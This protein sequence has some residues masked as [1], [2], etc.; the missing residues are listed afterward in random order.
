MELKELLYDY[1]QKAKDAALKLATASTKDKNNA[2]LLMAKKLRENADEIKT[3]NEKDLVAGKEKGLSDAMLDR[4]K[5][6]EDRINSMAEGVEKIASLVDPVGE[7][8]K[9]WTTEE[10]IKIRKTRVPI[11]VVG[12][13]YESRPNV[14]ADAAA[15]SLKSGN[16]IILRG[17]KEA[18]NSN[19]V[20]AKYL[21]E[22]I[23]EVGLPEDCINLIQTIDREAVKILTQMVG[24]IDMIIP[25]GGSGLIKAVTEHAKVPV[26]FHDKGLCH[27]YVDEFANFDMATK[28]C[29]NAKVQRP[30][31]CNAMETLLINKNIASTY[32]PVITDEFRNAGVELRGCKRSLEIVKDMKAAT[33]EDWDTE[34]L[35]MI[36]SIK[37]VDSVDEAIAHINKHGSKHSEC[38]ITDNYNNST[39][40][41]K[42]VDASTVYVNASTRFTDGAMFGF[43][44]EIGISTN[45]LHAR[46]PFA[47]EE[48]TTYKYIVEGE[49]QIR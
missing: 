42:S 4:L 23:K 2:L 24:Y 40:F 45:K 33:E 13:I 10:G 5:L 11:G 22:A 21:K 46:G 1:G 29:I 48:L 19:K 9:G 3:E 6:N 41:L 15:L 27:T 49:G 31:V 26:V 44:A 35:D 8:L 18:I 37:I 36:L 17:G 38:I 7:I 20:I 34:Y 25:R 16:S 28:I 39:K 12:M 32:L 47:L 43:G 14:T 30:G